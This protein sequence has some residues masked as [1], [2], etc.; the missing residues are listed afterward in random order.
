M[1][2]VPPFFKDIFKHLP[3]ALLDLISWKEMIYEVGILSNRILTNK[4]ATQVSNESS[5]SFKACLN[6]GQ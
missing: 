3:S 2:S 4:G 5:F 6:Q 1:L